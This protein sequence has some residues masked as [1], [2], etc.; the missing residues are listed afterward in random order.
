MKALIAFALAA[1]FLAIACT[2]H[3]DVAST[4]VDRLATVCCF[5]L[6][7]V[8]AWIGISNTEQ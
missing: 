8:C 3:P 4:S 2:I 7:V 6:S 5:I 1:I